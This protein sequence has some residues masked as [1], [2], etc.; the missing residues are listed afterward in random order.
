MLPRQLVPGA[1]GRVLE[2]GVAHVVDIEQDRP[3]PRMRSP[4]RGALVAVGVQARAVVTLAGDLDTVVVDL[5]PMNL[6]EVVEQ[7]LL[8]RQPQPATLGHAA[9]VRLRRGH[10]LPRRL[11]LGQ[12]VVRGVV[13]NLPDPLPQDLLQLRQ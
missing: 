13:V 11:R 5:A 7:V 1:V 6:E 10:A 4:V 12:T 8:D 2:V 3:L 9:G